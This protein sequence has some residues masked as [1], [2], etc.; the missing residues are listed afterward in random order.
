MN[1]RV[2]T[3]RHFFRVALLVLLTC[4]RLL[5]AQQEAGH[6]ILSG[7]VEQSKEPLS[8]AVIKVYKG[9]QPVKNLQ[10]GEGGQFEI[11][12]G[13]GNEYTIT[14]TKEGFVKKKIRVNSTVP[15][16]QKGEW[17]VEFPIGLFKEYPGLDVSALEEPVTKILYK[18]S[19]QGFGYAKRYTRKMMSRIDEILNQ[20][21]RLKDKAYQKIID[22]AD[23]LF[24]RHKYRESIEQ[25][26]KAL[27]KR[28]D[29]GYPSRQIDK[30]REAIKE[31]KAKKARY[32]K[33]IEKAD[34]QMD[35]EAFDQAKGLYQEALEYFPS[36]DYPRKQI[37][38]IERILRERRQQQAQRK[39]N[40]RQAID[41][42]DQHFSKDRLR[43]ARDG[44][45]KALKLFPGKEHPQERLREIA[46]R[47]E[48]QRALKQKYQNTIRQG[49]KAF[50]AENFSQATDLY[51]KAADMDMADSYPDEQLA[52]IDS[53]LEKR[54]AEQ[55]RYEKLI[56]Q[57]DKAFDREAYQKAK[58]A[59]SKAL[60]VKPQADYPR[61]QL[62]KIKQIVQR[63]QRRQ[64][65]YETAIARGDK[66]F[67]ANKYRM[68]RDSYQKA[69]EIKPKSTHPQNRLEKIKQILKERR[70]R[71]Q[72]YQSLIDQAD[73]A[74]D[75]E[76]YTQA[77]KSYQQALDVKPNKD[78]PSQQIHKIERILQ[79]LQQKKQA[80]QAYQEQIKQADQA[81]K[82]E[83]Y[84][85]AKG[86]YQQALSMKPN[87]PY[88]RQRIDRIDQI[89]KKR[90]QAKA[91]QQA[92]NEKYK[93]TIE[94]ADQRFEKETYKGA[95]TLYQKALSLKPDQ[96]YPRRQI[97]Q[98]EQILSKRREKNQNYQQALEAGDRHFDRENYQKA[99]QAYEKALS[100][101]P[102]KKYPQQQIAKIND[103]L[104]NKKARQQRRKTVARK[105]QRLISQADQY[106]NGNDYQQARK[107]YSEA[108]RVKPS[109]A[110]PPDQ[111][112]KIDSILEQKRR[113]REMAY[114]KAINKADSLYEDT[115]YRG[116]I[117]QYEKALEIKPK[118]EY[119][120][121]Q[122]G[123]IK[124][125][126]ARKKRASRRQKRMDSLY[127]QNIQKADALFDKNNYYDAKAFY[128]QALAYKP[129]KEYPQN[130]IRLCRKRIQQMEQTQA[131]RQKSE[132]HQQNTNPESKQDYSSSSSSDSSGAK[133]QYT[134]RSEL[135]RQYPEGITVEHK[136][137]EN[138][139]VKKVIVNY[140]GIA[141]VYRKVT[142]QWGKTFYFE[143]NTPI[144]KHYFKLKTSKKR[145]DS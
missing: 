23:R 9:S 145:D 130:R 58:G 26:Q 72:R 86:L 63:R 111:I 3:K 119:P 27:N 37:S 6:L 139:K 110:Y 18:R 123:R 136:D 79:R 57:G 67:E 28:P 135:A 14:F 45:K 68:A 33:A 10:S 113:E 66:H 115:H 22:Q 116:A 129:N 71:N 87:E 40:Y 51:Q 107:K 56:G 55:R 30:A 53:I 126:L 99:I 60:D 36:K 94:Q 108:S 100:I 93:Q 20:R 7:M 75:N 5:M 143:N 35:Q 62:Q 142:H 50:T 124:N 131:L 138:Y 91:R 59:Y 61:Q 42:A 34:E 134:Y 89:L 82:E 106:F 92:L 127:T 104:A 2:L 141:D 95:K 80:R 43:Q 41:Q 29:D 133:N 144:S 97:D 11:K 65:R 32:D 132:K 8:G 19:A 54:K 102:G 120:S 44:Y 98:I 31:L 105:Y 48:K 17:K 88:P 103:L 81:F 76:S 84:H 70:K 4:P 46:E 140:D 13:L 114:Q 12:M 109:E 121:R 38:K 128:Q 73:Q 39:E 24:E 16:G 118:A 78:Y 85:K 96:D 25:Y 83:Q 15:K 125:L 52:R 137:K 74:F 117:D 112:Q 1:Q 21:K 49:D 69:L 90:Q 64:Q 101:K 47:I 122:I 77:R